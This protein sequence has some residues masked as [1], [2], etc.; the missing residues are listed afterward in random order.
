MWLVHRLFT[1]T[2]KTLAHKVN[3]IKAH[4]FP[5]VTLAQSIIQS[6]SP[7]VSQ[8]V[9]RG[10]NPPTITNGRY[11]PPAVITSSSVQYIAKN[12]KKTCSVLY[13]GNLSLLGWQFT[14]K[15]VAHQS[16]I[17]SDVNYLAPCNHLDAGWTVPEATWYLL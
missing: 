4:A 17:N 11:L 1:C 10:H 8:T 3:T 13:T 7:T 15:Q 12:H 16:M 14:T 5:E 6:L 2:C 9:D